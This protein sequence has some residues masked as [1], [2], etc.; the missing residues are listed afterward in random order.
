MT[1]A[2]AAPAAAAPGHFQLDG[3]AVPFT[4][5]QTILQAASLAGHYIPHLCW[6]PD[7]APHGSCR[8]CSVVVNGRPGAACT[9]MADQGQ[10]VQS[11]TPIC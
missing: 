2:P 8:V 4:P 3:H 7:F 11:A 10:V 1:A 5:G 6:H 9:V